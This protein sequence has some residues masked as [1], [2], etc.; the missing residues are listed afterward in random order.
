MENL[1]IGNLKSIIIKSKCNLYGSNKPSLFYKINN[2][3]SS[4]NGGLIVLNND[5]SHTLGLQS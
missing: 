5:G 2:A 3:Y 1:V 4:V